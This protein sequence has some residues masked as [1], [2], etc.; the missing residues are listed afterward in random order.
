MDGKDHLEECVNCWALARIEPQNQQAR[1]HAI[2]ML[3]ETIKDKNPRVQGAAI[4]GLVDLKVPPKQLVPALAYV[5]LNGE[6][7][8]VGEALGALSVMGDEAAEALDD[9]LARPEARGRAAL[10]ITYLGPT[11]KATVPA[12]IKALDDKDPDV[13]REVLFALAAIGPDAAPATDAVLEEFA[14]PNVPNRAV[15]AFALGKIGPAA[16]AA[17]PKLQEELRSEDQLVRVASAFA[18]V[19]VAPNSEPIVTMAIPVLVHGLDSSVAAARRG[20]AEALGKI[21]KPARAAAEGALQAATLDPD[22]TVR[23]E[24]LRALESMGAVVDSVP[25]PRRPILQK[26]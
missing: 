20:A 4:R 2:K 14:D 7:P 3:L 21:G 18:L 6:E 13:R 10:L 22:E 19:N 1:E 5:V 9:A 16:K 24:A 11:A 8:A 15:A 26:R 17:L 12:L 25:Q 23:R